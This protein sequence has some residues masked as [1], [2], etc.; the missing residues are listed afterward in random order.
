MQKI[1]LSINHCDTL[2]LDHQVYEYGTAK[3]YGTFTQASN[4]A[5]K[6]FDHEAK[7]YFKISLERKISVKIRLM[8]TDGFMIKNITI[9]SNGNA[10]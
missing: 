5:I 3:E 2:F 4:R 9:K 1:I 10:N 6:D 8:D 7:E